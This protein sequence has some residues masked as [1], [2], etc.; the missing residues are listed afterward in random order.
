MSPASPGSCSP[1]DDMDNENK[2]DKENQEETEDVTSQPVRSPRV[3]QV[4][5]GG[6]RRSLKKP[7]FP[8]FSLRPSC[9]DDL[10]VLL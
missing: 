3:A 4:G 1:G 6:D 9:G 5:K 7:I 10:Q 2:E 8:T